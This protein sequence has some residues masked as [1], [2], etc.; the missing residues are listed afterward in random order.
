MQYLAE[1]IAA[2]R[3]HGMHLLIGAGILL[4][5][6]IVGAALRGRSPKA[7][8]FVA[9]LGVAIPVFAL[10]G[11]FGWRG[12]AEIEMAG[13]TEVRAY[14]AKDFYKGVQPDRGYI[15]VEG[16]AL[17]EFGMLHKYGLVV[18][19]TFSQAYCYPVMK[20]RHKWTTPLL[21]CSFGMEPGRENEPGTLEGV[22]GMR[23]VPEDWRTLFKGESKIEIMEGAMILEEGVPRPDKSRGVMLIAFGAAFVIAYLVVLAL[24]LKRQGS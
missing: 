13:R 8:T 5:L 4:A 2:V 20:K 21:A 23:R 18:M 15:Q 17:Y 10:S 7:G 11:W 14:E 1:L 9:M 6:V 3:G 12:L 19:G 22:Y 24:A 16:I